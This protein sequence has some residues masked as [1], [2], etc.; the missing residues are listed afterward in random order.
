MSK[1][2]LSSFSKPISCQVGCAFLTA[3]ETNQDGNSELTPHITN[4]KEKPTKFRFQ[5]SL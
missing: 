3:I 5:L 4:C 1:H 2:L